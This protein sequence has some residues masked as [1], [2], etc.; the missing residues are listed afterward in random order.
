MPASRR[1]GID[2]HQP[3]FMRRTCALLEQQVGAGPRATVEQSTDPVQRTVAG[4]MTFAL[5]AMIELPGA[6]SGIRPRVGSGAN[7]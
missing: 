2:D 7:A 4:S 3:Q 6:G 5:T 1:R